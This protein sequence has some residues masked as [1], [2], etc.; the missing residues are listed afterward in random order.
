MA[1]WTSQLSL[2]L[3]A[4]YEAEHFINAEQVFQ[5]LK[6]KD[7]DIGIATVYRNL[8]K[9]AGQ[10]LISEVSWEDVRYY[11]RHP[12]S[13]AFF[14]CER[15][16]RLLRADIPIANQNNLSAEVGMRVNRWKMRFEGVCGECERCT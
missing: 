5:K 11:T 8:K 15:C 9:L 2:T 14:V 7:E 16:G 3:D 4:V 1:R 6:Q 10:G 12:F 13:D